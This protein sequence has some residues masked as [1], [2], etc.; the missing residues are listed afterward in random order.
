M[1]RYE[2]VL[3]RVVEIVPL[4]EIA[5]AVARTLV[6]HHPEQ[7]PAEN[8]LADL[9]GEIPGIEPDVANVQVKALPD[10]IQTGEVRLAVMGIARRDMGIDDEGMH[11]IDGPVIKIEKAG[12][13]VSR[14]MKPASGS[15]VLTLT[16]FIVCG[17]GS[18]SSRL[19]DFFPSADLSST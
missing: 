18:S 12:Q 13:L 17:V 9:R 10:L 19:S 14:A 2:A 8:A 7:F 3:H 5:I 16:S 1:P 11:T 4:V 15:T 6:A